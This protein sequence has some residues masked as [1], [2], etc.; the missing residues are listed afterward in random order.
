MTADGIPVTDHWPHST[1]L[2]QLLFCQWE[3]NVI[4]ICFIYILAIFV[5]PLRWYTISCLPRNGTL[6][7]TA[8]D[9]RPLSN[10]V[11][12]SFIHELNFIL[13][14]LLLPPVY[15]EICRYIC[16]FVWCWWC[17]IA[18]IHYVPLSPH[19]F[20][21]L[22]H[23]HSHLL[24]AFLKAKLSGPIERCHLNASWTRFALFPMMNVF[25][26][27]RLC[28]CTRFFSL[29]LSFFLFFSY[30]MF[31]SLFLSLNW[32]VGWPNHVIRLH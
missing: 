16:L 9:W 14:S 7:T 28:V 22:S 13:L 25:V 2:S 27:I 12:A 4:I 10:D 6:C 3:L 17:I 15:A 30:L 8:V 26:C 11:G 5:L 24:N 18:F 21:S 23:S 19:F 1:T 29:F 20:L 32:L 31:A